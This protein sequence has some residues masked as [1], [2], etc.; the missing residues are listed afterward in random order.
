MDD[1]FNNFLVKLVIVLLLPNV[2]VWGFWEVGIN[3]NSNPLWLILVGPYWHIET[4]LV[5]AAMAIIAAGCALVVLFLATIAIE[6]MLNIYGRW[7]EYRFELAQENQRASE[8]AELRRMDLEKRLAFEALP[9]EEQERIRTK[10]QA[11]TDA[12]Q[13]ERQR[14][15]D[16]LENRRQEKEERLIKE[17]ELELERIRALENSP[18]Y[19]RKKALRAFVGGRSE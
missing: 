15:H 17:N 9:E 7:T 10:R 18:D 8:L 13:R 16:E 14:Q 3:N 5:F 4:Y 11:D 6:S 1:G 12:R 19:Q 2:L